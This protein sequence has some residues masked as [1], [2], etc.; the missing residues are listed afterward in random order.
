MI[1]IFINLWL[2]ADYN[3]FNFF[4]ITIVWLIA[5]IVIFTKYY[6][7]WLKDK[8]LV[9]H[10]IGQITPWL[11]FVIIP[12]LIAYNPSTYHLDLAQLLGLLLPV[13][14][15]G[16]SIGGFIKSIRREGNINTLIT[17][18]YLL[19]TVVY[20]VKVYFSIILD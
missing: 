13:T 2:T 7:P 6:L 19:A 4:F 10:A 3:F 11:A 17:M 9:P 1:Y 14:G 12:F 20:I 8:T 16:L 5:I 15:A 18:A